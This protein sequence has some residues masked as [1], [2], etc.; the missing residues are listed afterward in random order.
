[1][2]VLYFLE[3]I[4]N[5]VLDFFFSA[6]THLGEET[7]FI[8]LAVIFFWCI[9]KKQGYYLMTVGFIG[10][11]LNQFLKILFRIPRPWVKDPSFTIVESA[12]A[13]ATGYSFPSGHTQSSV[14]VFGAIARWNRNTALRIV[15]VVLCV[16]IP[17]SRLYLGVHTPLD[18]GVS[19]IIAIAL[20]FGL[21]PLIYRSFE[22]KTVMRIVLWSMAALS[23]GL[24][25][26]ASLYRF[27]ADVDPVHLKSTITN[28]YKM[29]GCTVGVCIV[30]ELDERF[31]K[32]S[33]AA[34]LPAQIIKFAVGIIPVIIIK[35]F[36]KAPLRALFNDHAFADALRYFLIVIFVGCVWPL[37]FKFFSRLFKKVNNE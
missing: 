3:S 17:L 15:C 25:A 4:R 13:E 34:S 36:L 12:R 22:N 28:G 31:I 1:M 2:T 19:I 37:S 20:I 18:V 5:S 33:T 30:Y 6:V 35:T 32:F 26:F 24:I 7:V 16:L 21:Y 29:L 9:D 27:P 23:V 14:G 10:T 11:I 8:L